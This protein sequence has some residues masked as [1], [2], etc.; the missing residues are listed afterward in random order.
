MKEIELLM[1]L[2]PRIL[3]ATLCGFIIGSEREIKHKVAGIRTHII[4]CVGACL[5][6]SISFVM[7]DAQTTF[8]PTRIIAQIVTGVGFLGA[9]LIFKNEDKVSG[10]TSAAFIWLTA[11]IGVIVGIGYIL[12]PIVFTVGLLI[13]LLILQRVEDKI[14]NIVKKKDEN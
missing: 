1:F 8:D 2:L 4:V 14:E 9:G 13:V 11:A 10:V 3:A 12:T 7:K 6:A 5:F